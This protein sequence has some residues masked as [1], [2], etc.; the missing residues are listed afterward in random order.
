MRQSREVG[1]W[2]TPATR[3]LITERGVH[4]IRNGDLLINS[5]GFCK[6]MGSYVDRGK[7]GQRKY[8]H[9]DGYHDDRIMALYI[10]LEVSH[11][12]DMANMSDERRKTQEQ[13]KQ[14]AGKVVQWQE[15]GLTWEEAMVKWEDQMPEWN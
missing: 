1:W 8:E 13:R 9:A 6:E 5:V 15:L 4:A 10:A 7:L 2:T 14:P 11:M 12:D 3:P